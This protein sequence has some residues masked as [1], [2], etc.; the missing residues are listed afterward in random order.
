MGQGAVESVLAEVD[1]FCEVQI[2]DPRRYGPL[3]LVVVQEEVSDD[4]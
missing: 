3:Q 1:L 4:S 2:I